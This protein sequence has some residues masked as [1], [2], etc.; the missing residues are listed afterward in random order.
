MENEKHKL[1]EIKEGIGR[2]AFNTAGLFNLEEFITLIKWAPVVVSV[3]TSTIHIAAATG[4][5]VIVLYALSNPQHSPWMAR[6]KV[7]LY[8]V[9]DEL[10]SRNQVVQ[11]VHQHLHPQDIQMVM[12]EEILH[13]IKDV[14]FG[15]GDTFIP[16]MIPLQKTMEQ[17]F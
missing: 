11:Y 7:L 10:R 15:D 4:T 5:P 3:N 14:L 12:P 16:A 8:D 9:P 6:G 2:N 1:E 17:V 13:A